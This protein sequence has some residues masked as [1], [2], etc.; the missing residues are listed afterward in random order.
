MKTKTLAQVVPEVER[1]EMEYMG[2]MEKRNVNDYVRFPLQIIL[3]IETSIIETNELFFENNFLFQIVSL[4]MRTHVTLS[5][6]SYHV[7]LQYTKFIL[8]FDFVC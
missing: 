6:L 3:I 5:I 4:I 1:K 7:K 8:L 2:V